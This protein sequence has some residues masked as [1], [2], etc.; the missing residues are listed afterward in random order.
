MPTTTKRPIAAWLIGMCAVF[1]PVAADF[2]QEQRSTAVNQ[3]DIPPSFGNWVLEGGGISAFDGA[4]NSRHS[5]C[6]QSVGSD[7]SVLQG[8]LA[9]RLE[10]LC[11]TKNLS[12]RCDEK[13]GRTFLSIGGWRETYTYEASYEFRFDDG[14][15]TD[16][17]RDRYS[18]WIFLLRGKRIVR[19]LENRNRL[20]LQ[21]LSST[22][23]FELA[24]FKELKAHTPWCNWR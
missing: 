12:L 19:E 4:R 22:Y 21:H 11:T 1:S 6:A 5:V 20:W 13:D 14:P 23:V 18:K 16:G 8:H 3:L 10:G 17:R 9:G 2:H 7:G 15:V 24:G